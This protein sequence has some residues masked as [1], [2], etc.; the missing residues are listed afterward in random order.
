MRVIVCL[1]SCRRCRWS[2]PPSLCGYP[3]CGYGQNVQRTVRDALFFLRVSRAR[4]A[5][6]REILTARLAERRHRH[7]SMKHGQGRAEKFSYCA[8]FNAFLSFRAETPNKCKHEYYIKIFT[9]RRCGC[10]ARSHGDGM[11]QKTPVHRLERH[12]RLVTWRGYIT[13]CVRDCK[14]ATDDS[15]RV[16]KIEAFSRSFHS[17]NRPMSC[18]R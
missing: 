11:E 2:R 8:R 3:I 15:R 12:V 10:P 7:S 4:R 5:A 13:I 14:H 17:P 9:F 18:L 6:R 1:S 16:V